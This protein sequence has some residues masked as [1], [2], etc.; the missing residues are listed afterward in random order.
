M[1]P[2][3]IHLGEYLIKGALARF[4]EKLDLNRSL[5]TAGVGRISEFFLLTHF[6]F[7]QYISE[8]ESLALSVTD[9][10]NK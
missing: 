2:H 9:M 1:E 5:W 6:F 3:K 8:G 10:T 7:Y 4:A